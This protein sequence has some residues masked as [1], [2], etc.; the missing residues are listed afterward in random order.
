MGPNDRGA[1]VGV[2][3]GDSVPPLLGHVEIPSSHEIT[4]HNGHVC[5]F[6]GWVAST[7]GR[8]TTVRV[9]GASQRSRQFPVSQDRPDVLAV[10]REDW[11]IQDGP[12]GFEFYVDLPSRRWPRP[13][14]ITVEL[15]DG[16]FTIPDLYR[17][18]PNTEHVLETYDNDSASKRRLATRWLHGRGL[19]F[20]ALHQPLRVDYDRATVEYAD[21]LT[22]AE[23]I[24]MFPDVTEH[25]V[26]AMV[27]PTFIVDL[28]SGD[29]SALNGEEFDF[30]VASDVIEHVANPM[31]FLK[32]VHDIMKPGARLLLSVPDRRY[33]HDADRPRTSN[34]HLWREYVRGVTRVD[35]R[36]LRRFLKGSDHLNIP[37]RRSIREQLYEM[38]RER[39]VHVHVWDNQSFDRFLDFSRIRIPLQLTTLDAAPSSE[40]G[41]AMVYVFEREPPG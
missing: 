35:N 18:A 19:E 7:R 25:F 22:K 39:S 11:E 9:H 16:E 32:A 30:F 41:G 23:A 17:V 29:L 4:R 21:R 34:R 3:N 1:Q 28:N 26:D 40:A 13:P 27:E 14:G 10:L 2:D 6:R 5:R 31:Q 24:E 15:T 38:H 33:T 8:P 36:H 12:V 37:W 20:G